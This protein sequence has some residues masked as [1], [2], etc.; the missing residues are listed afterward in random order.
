MKLQDALNLLSLSGEVTFEEAKAAY[1]RAC[2]Q[3]HPDRNPAGS[4]M[5]KAIT[6]AW[7]LL[8]KHDWAGSP[9]SVKAGKNHGYGEALME[10]LNKIIHLPDITI[11]ICGAWVWVGGNTKPVKDQ[12]KAAGYYWA[13]KKH[14]WYFRPPEWASANRY[15]EW[16]IDA[17]REKFDSEEIKTQQRPSIAA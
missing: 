15:G 2:M 5:M 14:M 17:I 3:Y 11:E 12:I 6:E 1:R 9:V 16:T 4:E 10:A 7:R 8:E 13:S